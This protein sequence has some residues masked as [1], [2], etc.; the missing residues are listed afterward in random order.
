MNSEFFVSIKKITDILVEPL[1]FIKK[2]E[3]LFS[4]CKYQDK[5]KLSPTF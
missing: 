1:L 5:I 2:K 3:K 4:F